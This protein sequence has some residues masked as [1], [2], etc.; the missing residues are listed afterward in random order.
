LRSKVVVKLSALDAFL[1]Q[2]D[3]EMIGALIDLCEFAV[4]RP[5]FG[6]EGHPGG[7]AYFWADEATDLLIGLFEDEYECEDDG[8]GAPRAILDM[9]RGTL[10]LLRKRYRRRRPVEE[11]S[12]R[13]AV[14]SV[15]VRAIADRVN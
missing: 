4:S 14:A 3:P 9:Q 12:F 11:R 15:R 13:D 1:D 7:E 6:T 8:S 5:E 2:W 10:E